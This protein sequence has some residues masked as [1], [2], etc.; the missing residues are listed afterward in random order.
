MGAL[1]PGGPIV[2]PSLFLLDRLD[3]TVPELPT[4]ELLF[5]LATDSW[6]MVVPNAVDEPGRTELLERLKDEDDPLDYEHLWVVGTTLLGRLAGTTALGGTGEG[7]FPAVRICGA[8]LSQWMLFS[9]WCAA[10]GMDPVAAPLYRVVAAGYQMLR[11]GCTEEKDRNNLDS[12]I[13]APAPHSPEA[14]PLIRPE[15][16]AAQAHAVL[17]ELLGE[18][19]AA[20][21]LGTPWAS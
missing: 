8:L 10:H 17:E 7:Y 6:W 3:Y 20:G 12:R 16:E 21:A 5:A 2:L 14:V 19:P 13:W 9:G 18:S 11:E 15:I 1:W 4:R